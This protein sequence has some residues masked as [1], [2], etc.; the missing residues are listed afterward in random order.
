MGSVLGR[1]DLVLVLWK[2]EY[3]VV[4]ESTRFIQDATHCV[5]DIQKV[6]QLKHLFRLQLEHRLQNHLR[7]GKPLLE[8]RSRL[9]LDKVTSLVQVL[10]GRRGKKMLSLSE[11]NKDLLVLLRDAVEDV[12][13]VLGLLMKMRS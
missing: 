13:R 3:I 8:L 12:V 7:V 1:L 6:A 11:P 2:A 10:V 9:I 5:R 4:D